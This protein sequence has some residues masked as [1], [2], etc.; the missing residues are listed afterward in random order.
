M[1]RKAD[2]MPFVR[3]FAHGN[4]GHAG[5]THYVMTGVD[6]P[7]ADAGMP[8]IKP[9]FGSITA[10]V[11]GTNNPGSGLPTYVRLSGLYADGPNWLGS[12]Y[13]PFDV[14]GE[15]RNNMTVNVDMSRPGDRRSLL[16]QID[17][18]NRKVDRTGQ[19][20]G[21]DQFESQAF[22]LILGRAKEAFDLTREDPR[23]RDKYNSAG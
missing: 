1:A 22:D 18:I 11:R 3:S 17:R 20:T 12:A 21:L 23:L 6:Y 14:G 10:R 7:P 2:Q 5:G 8:P 16:G 4:S 15:P 9:S 19:M 13:S